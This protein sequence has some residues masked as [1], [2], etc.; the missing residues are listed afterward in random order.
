[1]IINNPFEHFYPDDPDQLSP[2]DIHNLFV[3]EYTEHNALTAY[4][5]TIVEGSR[6]SGKSMLFK[7]MEPAC[8][9]IEHKGWDN[10][11]KT[12]KAF[13]GIYINCNTGN[14]RKSEFEELLKCSDVP[15]ILAEKIIVHE[16][17]MRIV[18]WALKTI[19]EQLSG[20]CHVDEKIFEK[21]FSV[22]DMKKLYSDTAEYPRTLIGLRTSVI[23]ERN[24]VRKSLEDF[25]NNYAVPG[26]RL[27][28]SGNF[29]EPSFTEHSFLFVF[30]YSMRCLLGAENI[31]FFLL[32]DEAGDLMLLPEQQKVINTLITQRIQSL[33]CIKVSARPESYGTET[34]LFG[35]HIQHIHDYD[36]INLDSLYTNNT[37]AYYQRI[38]EISNKRL[39]L[40]GFQVT[41]I[42]RFIP[43]RDW[44]IE[45]MEEAEKFTGEE[46]D[47]LPEDSRPEDKQN[48]VS[49][50][51]RARFFQKFLVKSPYWYTG[52]NNLVHF[53]AGITRSFL[54]PCFEMV[55]RY[56]QKHPGTD[57]KT[58][59]FIPYEI[60][61]E[62][63]RDFSNNFIDK[64]L[65]VRIKRKDITSE[66]RKI[67]QYLFNLIESLGKSFKI[68]LQNPKSRYPRIISFSIKETLIEDH[69]LEVVL[70]KA[71]Q[72]C[73]FQKRWYRGKSGYEMLECYIL[74]RRLC[75]RYD[76]DLSGFQG[77]VELS[78]DVLK[79]AMKD[80][81]RF[82]AWFKSKEK[83]GETENATQLELFGV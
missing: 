12:F 83:T 28:Y 74:N 58:I 49:K 79:L 60:Q 68:R 43:E 57:M 80:T 22:L 19:S 70:K 55:E 59:Q 38:L 72:E 13:I 27:N 17:I 37:E 54:D 65:L 53:S 73:F 23:N 30:F 71:L 4:K 61:W 21:I 77:R 42:R 81:S 62:V 7:F 26:N 20:R 36:T 78:E 8:Q 44:E 24:L 41:D 63:I 3:K 48:Y 66:D 76:L 39:N 18:E 47:N 51:A 14:Y 11:L 10:F 32:F 34:D 1:M 9:E 35:K 75:P 25:F 2:K 15:K 5:H 82:V 67:L 64:E 33:V 31:P 69:D 40:A 50:Y 56:M 6:G 46:Y 29:T 45:R 52:F 16:F